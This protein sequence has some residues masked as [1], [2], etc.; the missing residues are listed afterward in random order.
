MYELFGRHLQYIGIDAM[1]HVPRGNILQRRRNVVH[2]VPSGP[3]QLRWLTD[4]L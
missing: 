3:N 4:L 1:L 2:R